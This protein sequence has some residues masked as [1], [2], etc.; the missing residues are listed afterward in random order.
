[1]KTMTKEEIKPL[2]LEETKLKEEMKGCCLIKG[3]YIDE[4][5]KAMFNMLC[6]LEDFEIEYWN[7]KERMQKLRKK[8]YDLYYQLLC[9]K[10]DKLRPYYDIDKIKSYGV[11]VWN[12]A[13]NLD[14]Q[15]NV[16]DIMGDKIVFYTDDHTIIEEAKPIIEDIQ[17][18]IKKYYTDIEE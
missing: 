9:E 10:V 17:S 11:F 18:F 13:D 14:N 8:Y 12:K 4:N 16:F 15:D 2:S 6:H 3:K 1:M 7:L 5:T